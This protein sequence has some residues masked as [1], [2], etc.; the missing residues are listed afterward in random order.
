MPQSQCVIALQPSP[1][2]GHAHPVQVSNLFVEGHWAN[3]FTMGE[4]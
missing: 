3:G 4:Q 2:C 1:H